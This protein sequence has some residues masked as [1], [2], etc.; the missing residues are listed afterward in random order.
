MDGTKIRKGTKKREQGYTLIEILIGVV[1]LAIGLLA[2][3]QMQILT[4]TTNT[5]ANQKTTA[6]TLAQDQVE[7][8][9]MRP[10]NTLG[11]PPLSDSSGIYTRSWTVQ[12]N[13]PAN[14]MSTVTVTVS[15]Q[16]KQVQMQTIIASGN[17]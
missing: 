8:L 2:V 6:I 5:A 17:L 11:N 12:A 3:A 4:I 10:Y 16:G 7:L 9:R 13:T 1:L 14:N 15:W